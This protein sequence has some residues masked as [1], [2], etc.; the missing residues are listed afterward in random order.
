MHHDT[1]CIPMTSRT[2]HLA[3]G[4]LVYSSSQKNLHCLEKVSFAACN[5]GR[6]S[7]LFSNIRT[8]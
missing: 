8:K 5:E 7:A 2:T 4:F 6:F 3:H 1:P